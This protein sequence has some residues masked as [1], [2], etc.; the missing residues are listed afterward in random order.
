M[1]NILLLILFVGVGCVHLVISGSHCAATLVWRLRRYSTCE[2]D[3]RVWR[4][5]ALQYDKL[6]AQVDSKTP[7]SARITVYG[8]ESLANEISFYAFPRVVVL[9]KKPSGSNDKYVLIKSSSNR[10]NISDPDKSPK[11]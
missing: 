2:S 7:D 3:I 8:P 10:W 1:L 4:K 11:K 5:E 6:V 9:K